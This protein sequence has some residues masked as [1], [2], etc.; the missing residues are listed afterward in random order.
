MSSVPTERPVKTSA[1]SLERRLQVYFTLGSAVLLIA[2]SGALYTA[3][4]HYMRSQMLAALADKISGGAADLGEA[5]GLDDFIKEIAIPPTTE[6]PYWVRALNASR[7]IAAES[8]GMSAVIPASVFPPASPAWMATRDYTGPRGQWM[9]LATRIVHANGADYTV[10][11]AADRMTDLDF[12]QELRWL[13]GTA[14]VAGVLFSG[15]IARVATRRAL[16]PLGAME[17][18]VARVRA[19]RLSE[20]LGGG[21]PREL[22]PLAQAFDEMMGRLED[23]FT[24]LSQFSADLAHELRTPIANLRGEA[25]VALT[26]ARTADEYR[27][28]LE[29]SMEEYERLTEMTSRL[30]FLA[31]AEAAETQIKTADVDV[32]VLIE[33]LREF[34]EP[35]AEEREVK[36][37][38]AG[39]NVA[40]KLKADP[41]LLR[42]AISNLIENALR[43]TPPG[44]EVTIALPE[45]N[46][47]TVTDTGCGIPPEHL[48]RIFDRFYQV[49][50]SRRKGGTGLGLALV[51]SIMKMHGGDVSIA[52]ETGR[53]TEV[54]LRFPHSSTL[55]APWGL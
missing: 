33:E 16:R 35:Y 1:W 11:V 32:R 38:C 29:S 54:T 8:S 41:V 51:K 17:H 6:A 18:A 4:R 19:P 46:L 22:A 2:V 5:D 7:A 26:R 53:G 49:D 52:S 47:V 28:V 21:W 14:I 24:R 30:L 10:Q 12:L 40:E 50:P 27:N 42:R 43:H 34:Y 48:P 23:S 20:R 44:G 55:Y 9:T 45:R 13:F 3:I 25:E 15:G 39:G 31:R 36:L 37:T